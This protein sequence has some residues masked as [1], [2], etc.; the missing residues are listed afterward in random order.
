MKNELVK[1]NMNNIQKVSELLAEAFME[2]PL[3]I[4]F[5]Q[6]K[7]LREKILLKIY[8]IVVE[9][10]MTIGTVYATSHNIE[11]VIGVIDSR[12]INYKSKIKLL[13]ILFKNFKLIKYIF[14]NDIIRKF[15]KLPKV[16]E[17]RDQ[18]K[19]FYIEMVAVD[20]R[21]RKKG[22]MSKLIRAVTSEADYRGYDCVLET[23]T[24]GNVAKYKHLGFKV[25]DKAECSKGMVC[26]YKMVYKH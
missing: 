25:Y 17:Y 24:L 11:G 20:K 8:R 6:E 10:M 15:R 14:T 23:E 19:V 7:V 9:V 13:K 22:Y 4:Y 12:K 26:K 18:E 16:K 5:F 21:Y 1:L 2:N 3:M